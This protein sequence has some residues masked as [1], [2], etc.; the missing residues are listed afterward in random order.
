MEPQA[1]GAGALVLVDF[2]GTLTQ[3]DADFQVAEAL[4]PAERRL[5][6]RP[7][8]ERYERLEIGLGEYFRGL[9][10]LVDRPP[11]DWSRAARGVALRPGAREFVARCQAAGMEVRIVSEGLDVYIRP[12]LEAHGL[13]GVELRCNRLVRGPD[14]PK[15]LPAEAGASCGR[16]LSCKGV[17]VDRAHACGWTVAVVGDGASDLC[18]ARVA[19]RVY[20]TA[21]LR[22]HCEREGLPHVSWS[23]LGQVADDLAA[24][25]QRLGG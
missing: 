23:G 13:H 9:L 21:R 25:R 24:W 4:L 5:A 22:D 12:I 1:A 3:E 11:Q 20:A 15:V 6:Y 7:L 19:D 17:W 8:A 16:C 18:A 14:G 10:E 2:D